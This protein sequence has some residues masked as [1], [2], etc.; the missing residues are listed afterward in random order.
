MAT[1]EKSEL[2]AEEALDLLGHVKSAVHARFEDEHGTHQ[3]RL[4]QLDSALATAVMAVEHL[5]D[6]EVRERELAQRILQRSTVHGADEVV[7]PVRRAHEH[8]FAIARRA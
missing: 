2:T 5:H 4:S 6:E 8:T 7:S 1:A 3:A